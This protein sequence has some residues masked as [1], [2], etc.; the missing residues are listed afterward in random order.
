M[1]RI[2]EILEASNILPL[3]SA[4]IQACAVNGVAYAVE[5]VN[6][7]IVISFLII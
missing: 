7:S 5:V 4:T 6:A 2:S 3:L 1:L